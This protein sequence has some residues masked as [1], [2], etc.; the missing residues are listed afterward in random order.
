MSEESPPIDIDHDGHYRQLFHDPRMVSD[1]LQ[2]FIDPALLPK[3]HFH[4]LER[5]PD[6]HIAEQLSGHFKRR[7]QGSL[8][9]L[10]VDFDGHTEAVYI[11][12]LLEF[13]SRSDRLM[14]QRISTYAN[15]AVQTLIKAGYLKPGD[16]IPL[17]LPVV[18][19]NGEAPWSA[20]LKLSELQANV[21]LVLRRYQPQMEYIVIDQR[22]IAN[23]PE[24]NLVSI[25]CR[26]ERFQSPL[27]FVRLIQHLYALVDEQTPTLFQSFNGWIG[28]LLPRHIPGA[29]IGKIQ[30]KQQGQTMINHAYE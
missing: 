18:L 28:A 14:A 4:T 30:G 15:L 29:K 16:P 11:H 21:P 23:L 27:D 10:L 1:L 3:P 20:P 19:Y 17:M 13:Q 9:R 6:A 5:I 8:W 12:L 7:H 2:G 22:R 25:L 26:G 24:G